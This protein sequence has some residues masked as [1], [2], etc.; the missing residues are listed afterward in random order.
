MREKAE[1]GSVPVP[2]QYMNAQSA[3]VGLRGKD[4][5]AAA[6]PWIDDSQAL[7]S[8]LN[9]PD[10]LLARIS[11]ALAGARRDGAID[12][13]LYG[14][15]EQRVT[16]MAGIQAA[17]ERIAG[18]P[19][20]FAYSVM[21]HRTVYFFCAALPFGLVESIGYFTPVFS[22]FVAYTFMA[23]EAIAS[24]LED[25]FGTEDNDLALNALSTTIEDAVRDLLG[26]PSLPPRA[27]VRHGVIVD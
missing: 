13:L 21:I 9:T 27:G 12:S 24:Q 8:R 16:A 26:E 7:S 19:L 17:C 25:P 6:R 1:P 4:M 11:A 22:V 14:V 20:P 15:L 2:T 18:T 3:I 5:Q 23:H 10:L